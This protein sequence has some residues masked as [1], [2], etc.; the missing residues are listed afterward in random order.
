MV[1]DLIPGMVKDLKAEM[2][3]DLIAAWMVKDYSWDG[4]GFSC[5]QE[6]NSWDG[7]GFNS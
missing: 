7:Q 4:P 1:K 6:I 5:G 3:K 2:V